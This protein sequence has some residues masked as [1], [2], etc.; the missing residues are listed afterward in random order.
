MNDAKFVDYGESSQN[1]GGGKAPKK[2]KRRKKG[3]EKKSADKSK[4]SS[5]AKTGKHVCFEIVGF[6]FVLV[7]LHFRQP[8]ASDL[9]FTYFYMASLTT[10]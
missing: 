8:T 7:F 2:R 3:Q 5:K 4:S 6:F 1:S 9:F 10:L